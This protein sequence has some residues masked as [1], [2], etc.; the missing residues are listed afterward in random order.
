MKTAPL[1]R[2]KLTREKVLD[3]LKKNPRGKTTTELG[4]ELKISRKTIEKHL[5]LL[6]FENEAYMKQFGP[7][8]V[9]YPNKRLHYLDFKKI[10][11]NNKTIWFDLMENEYGKYLLIQEKREE[12]K[13]FIT[14]GS[15]LIPL[16][17][18]K[19]F[20]NSLNKLLKENKLKELL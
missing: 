19:L 11:L 17:K 20:V 8:R 10:N 12:D 15:I 13:E 18:A 2:E 14:K 5:Q 6:V 3:Y 9:Y 7:T 1:K 4:K 16:N